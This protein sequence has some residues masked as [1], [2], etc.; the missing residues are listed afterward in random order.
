MAFR[1]RILLQ[2]EIEC[3]SIGWL[4]PLFHD[5]T[6]EFLLA[7]AEEKAAAWSR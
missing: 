1:K 7:G 2:I 5:Y 4:P 3:E 6:E